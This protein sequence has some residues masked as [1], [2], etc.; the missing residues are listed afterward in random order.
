MKH[1]R[2]RDPATTYTAHPIPPAPQ[3]LLWRRFF[4]AARGIVAR[5]TPRLLAQWDEAATW[6]GAGV[7]A[8]GHGGSVAIQGI[9]EDELRVLE[10]IMLRP[11]TVKPR[12]PLGGR[13]L[14]LK[15]DGLKT[16]FARC[17]TLSRQGGSVT[18]HPADPPWG[19]N[20]DVFAFQRI[21]RLGPGWEQAAMVTVRA[22]S[23]DLY[24]YVILDV[25]VKEPP[26]NVVDD[27]YSNRDKP[28]QIAYAVLAD[29]TGKSPGYLA[30]RISTIRRRH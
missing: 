6:L 26:E 24:R 9:A 17:R 10:T 2:T 12:P 11:G 18:F 25:S 3:P 19:G 1:L 8:L 27:C 14:V 16:V 4:F 29:L 28:A 23:R 21:L 30:K 7:Y 22:N 13:A 15:Y 20:P 5:H